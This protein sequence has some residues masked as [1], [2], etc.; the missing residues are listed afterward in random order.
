MSTMLNLDL[1]RRV[2]CLNDKIALDVWD[3]SIHGVDGHYELDIPFNKVPPDLPNNKV[4][5]ERRLEFLRRKMVK[6]PEFATRYKTGMQGYIDEGYA[7]KGDNE[8]GPKGM[9][10]YIPHHVVF[11]VNKP[12]KLRIVFD[13]AATYNDV[14]ITSAV[15]LGPD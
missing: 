13:C 4:M 8:K 5:A 9:V 15:H 3:R 12:D 11:N 10:W 6:N 14:S 2:R 7:E 1:V